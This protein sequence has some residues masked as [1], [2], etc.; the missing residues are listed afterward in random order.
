MDRVRGIMSS[1]GHQ[2]EEEIASQELWRELS[3]K[4]PTDD[5][6]HNE[7]DL[8]KLSEARV[9]DGEALMRLRDVRIEKDEK[10]NNL[11]R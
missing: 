2:L 4:L 5:K 1:L 8:S 10:K 9:L 7:T 11:A 6:L 3:Q